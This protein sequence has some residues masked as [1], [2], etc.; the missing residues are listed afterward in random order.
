MWTTLVSELVKGLI[1]ATLDLGPSS[2]EQHLTKLD[3][4]VSAVKQH[5]EQDGHIDDD[6]N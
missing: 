6:L 2:Q 4:S 3:S 1:D 5:L